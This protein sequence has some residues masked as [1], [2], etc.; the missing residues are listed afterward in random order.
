MSIEF[1]SVRVRTRGTVTPVTLQN[2]NIKIEKSDKVALLAATTAGLDLLVDA[3]CAAQA[4]D[5]GRVVRHASLS[6]PLPEAPFLHKHQTFTANARFIARLYEVDQKSF[7]PKVI[8]LAGIQQLADERVDHCPSK[9]ISQ[10]SFALAV[11]L[12]FDFYLFTRTSIGTKDTREKYSEIIHE[13]GTRSGLIVA[14]SNAKVAVPFC[15]KAFV[16]EP[17]GTVYY[18]DME[19]A[20]AHLERISEGVAN[21]VDEPVALDQER[22]FDDFF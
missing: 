2:I 1:R 16:I 8:D 3:L 20:T 18:E 4:T 14:T 9:L 15:D 21:E 12:P 22:V 5:S 13:V 10:F 7:I 6:W 19:A 11:S 17:D